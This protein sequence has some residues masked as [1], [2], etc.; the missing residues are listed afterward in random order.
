MNLPWLPDVNIWLALS[1]PGHV[2]Q[3][4]TQAWLTGPQG[5]L[6]FCRA[7]QQGFLRLLT[8]QAVVGPYGLKAYSNREAT[9]KMNG[10]LAT[11][12]I[13]LAIDEPQGLD[14]V[15][16]RFADSNQA[17]PKLWMD[18][19]LAAFAVTGGY[20]LVTTDKAFKQFKGLDV[21]VLK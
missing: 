7:S 5:S 13:G 21:L 2:H 3:A 11:G 10:L 9:V 8:T 6:W 18:A 16:A 19:Y 17:S 12:R 1:L 20:R 14:P 15:W 4:V